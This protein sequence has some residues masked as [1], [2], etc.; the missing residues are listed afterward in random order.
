[1]PTTLTAVVTPD[2][3]EPAPSTPA[4][5]IAAARRGEPGALASLYEQYA[6]GLTTA[7][8]RIL[9]SPDEA[10]DVVQDLFV[11]LPEALGR[12]AERGQLGAWLRRV[13]VRLALG[14]ARARRRREASL[15]A[16]ADPPDHRP[17]AS[18]A[19]ADRLAL[20]RAIAA[21]PEPLRLVFVLREVEGYAHAEIAALLGISRSASEVRLFRAVRKLRALLEA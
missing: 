5:L 9:G 18:D 12:Y 1:M 8:A 15:D 3:P 20:E 17:L 10:E 2:P 4:D 11:A 21:L 19:F 16:A 13:A 14:R 6:G 7:V